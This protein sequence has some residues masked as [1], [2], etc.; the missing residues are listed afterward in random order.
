MAPIFR[1]YYSCVDTVL[2]PF[3]TVRV[4]SFDFLTHIFFPVTA[5]LLYNVWRDTVVT[6]SYTRQSAARFCTRTVEMLL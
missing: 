2:L 1:A 6:F 5:E 3:Y 4:N